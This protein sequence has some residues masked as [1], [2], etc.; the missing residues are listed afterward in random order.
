M[1]F[2]TA[3]DT[4]LNFSVLD[5][6]NDPCNRQ[7]VAEENVN[8]TKF[9]FFAYNSKTIRKFPIL[10]SVKMCKILRSTILYMEVISEK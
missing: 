4:N 9:Q 10:F 8:P 7:G 6:D 3:I 1:K 5:F 2:C